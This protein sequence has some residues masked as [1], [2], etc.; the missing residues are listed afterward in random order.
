VARRKSPMEMYQEPSHKDRMDH[1]IDEAVQ[2][3]ALEHPQT[4]KLMKTIKAD[5]LKASKAPKA[6]KK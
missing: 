1:H 4:K 5:M 6:K 2:H 3:A